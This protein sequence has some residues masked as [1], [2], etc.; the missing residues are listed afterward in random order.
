MSFYLHELAAEEAQAGLCQGM[1]GG[2]FQTLAQQAL[3]PET[4]VEGEDVENLPGL[5]EG[6]KNLTDYLNEASR[7]GLVH[8]DG[9]VKNYAPKTLY[10]WYF[11]LG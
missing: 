6:Y 11:D 3:A 10:K 2:K 8:P 1:C 9:E 7:K 4:D 5:P